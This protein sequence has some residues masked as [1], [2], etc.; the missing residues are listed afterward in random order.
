MINIL[1]QYESLVADYQVSNSINQ[2]VKMEEKMYRFATGTER[3]L[4]VSEIIEK[5]ERE[6]FP[7]RPIEALLKAKTPRGG[8]HWYQPSKKYGGSWWC[9]GLH[10]TC[11][12]KLDSNEIELTLKQLGGLKAYNIKDQDW[13]ELKQ[14]TIFIDGVDCGKYWL[15]QRQILSV[16]F[17]VIGN[18]HDRLVWRLGRKLFD[19]QSQ[20]DEAISF[21]KHA[22]PQKW[23]EHQQHVVIEKVNQDDDS[24]ID[25]AKEMGIS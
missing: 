9:A 20:T 10:I 13:P 12:G 15:T 3:N 1:I 8:R 22:Y 23:E 25:L 7:L 24:P 2:E 6:N 11:A 16:D 5:F 21:K 4:T 19:V 17:M 18:K 14:I